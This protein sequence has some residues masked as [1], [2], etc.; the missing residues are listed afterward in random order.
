MKKY[1]VLKKDSQIFNLQMA[2]G[3]MTLLNAI[4]SASGVVGDDTND[5]II[6]ENKRS[7]Y[8]IEVDTDED[9]NI[10]TFK[11][12]AFLGTLT[13]KPR[14]S[15]VLFATKKMSETYS[16]E[17]IEVF[18]N[19]EMV[20]SLLSKFE[21]ANIGDQA[22]L[23]LLKPKNVLCTLDPYGIKDKRSNIATLGINANL[24]EPGENVLL[25]TI[26]ALNFARLVKIRNASKKENERII[27]ML[28]PLKTV[29]NTNEV[30][31]AQTHVP[32]DCPDSFL[33]SYL[34]I[35]QA[36]KIYDLNN[37][38]KHEFKNVLF[39]GY[40]RSMGIRPFTIYNGFD[41]D[42]YERLLEARPEFT[43]WMARTFRLA[44][45]EFE[46][47][48]AKNA[49]KLCEQL[50]LFLENQDTK[51]L[52]ECIY[53]LKKKRTYKSVNEYV[54]FGKV[55]EMIDG[56]SYA[57]VGDDA[58]DKLGKSLKKKYFHVGP[59]ESIVRKKL[60]E[61]GVNDGGKLMDILVSDLMEDAKLNEE[62]GS[63]LL[64]LANEQPNTVAKSILFRAL[65]TN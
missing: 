65:L 1:A 18:S 50:G 51:Y 55:I 59:R 13:N 56:D 63:H 33:R 10:D 21:Y 61:I 52:Y 36:K 2:Y 64:K 53:I 11:Y 24:L 8:I 47:K 25:A 20:C 22:D 6:L 26:G 14:L 44:M 46:T 45:L 31:S 29:V 34:S 28:N 39:V 57:L 41:F 7:A 15:V 12:S 35:T 3:L 54:D 37:Y 17:L 58:V 16:S 32:Y 40:K 60:G 62:E 27:Y 43:T 38:S 19:L 4:Y 30:V 49:A 48:S 42:F 5:F 23:Q 9:P